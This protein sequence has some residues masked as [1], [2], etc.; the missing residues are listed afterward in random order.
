MSSLLV[1]MLSNI[2]VTNVQLALGNVLQDRNDTV[3]LPRGYPLEMLKESLG[4]NIIVAMR[5]HQRIVLGLSPKK[6]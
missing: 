2:H 5:Y 3:I 4:R 1:T 6:D